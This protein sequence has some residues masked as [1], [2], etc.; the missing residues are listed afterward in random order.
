MKS[1][2]SITTIYFLVSC[3]VIAIWIVAS[4][5]YNLSLTEQ[6]NIFLG[7]PNKADTLV[8]LQEEL[9][10]IGSQLNV[11]SQVVP[12]KQDFETK[13][14][15]SLPSSSVF[16]FGSDRQSRI[17]K[18]HN[19]YYSPASNQYFFVKGED[20]VEENVQHTEEGLLDLTSLSGHNVFYW[21]YIDIP[22]DMFVDVETTLIKKLTFLLSRFHV[23][24][25]MHTLHDDVLGLYFVLKMF[26]RSGNSINRDI[27]LLLIDGWL[28][29][30]YANI[31]KHFTENPLLFKSDLESYKLVCFEDVVVGNSK[32]TTWYQY[33]FVTPQGGIPNKQASGYDIRQVTKYI[34]SRIE[35]NE[36]SKKDVLKAL[37]NMKTGKSPNKFQFVIFSRKGDRLIL[38]E[39]ELAAS[40]IQKFQIPVKILRMED[41]DF[42][43]QVA[44]LTDTI[45]GIGMHG[46]LLIMSMFM[47]KGAILVEMY[48]YSVPSENYTP[49]KILSNLPGMDITYRAWQ[50]TYPENTIAFPERP[51]HL[52]GLLHLEESEQKRISDL[53]TVPTHLCCSD[54]V[55]LHKIYQDTKV[56]IEEIIELVADGIDQSMGKLIEE[57]SFTGKKNIKLDYLR[58]SKI[59]RAECSTETPNK[60]TLKW[61]LPW[62][63]V[64]PEKYGIWVH[65]TYQ[66]YFSSESEFLLDCDSGKVYEFWIRPFAKNRNYTAGYS[67]KVSCMCE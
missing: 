19:L 17:C 15:E 39:H 45:V 21:D 60:I 30:P 64:K 27:N 42:E 40:L 20:S 34:R 13:R 2:Q 50:N 46:S 4:F 54:P 31:F 18:F 48:P 24:N 51:Q 58:P 6:I 43:E 10:H 12:E 16:C 49:Y 66:E 44:M 29:G 67:E 53:K 37:E 3:S 65:Q 47:P 9:N 62:N 55:W 8:M 57:K 61:S 25:I 41:H 52:G 32:K 36:P 33:G 59:E 22:K 23:G 1:V 5:V 38:N 28:D 56:N 35:R 63:T 26:A 11:L 7:A 14:F